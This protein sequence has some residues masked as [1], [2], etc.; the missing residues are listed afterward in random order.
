MERSCALVQGAR[1]GEEQILP[2]RRNRSHRSAFR[3]LNSTRAG[4]D[5]P[6]SVT[7]STRPLTLLSTAVICAAIPLGAQAQRAARQPQITS[8]SAPVI[9]QNGLRFR[10]LNRN[11]KLD[12]YEDW[13]LTPAAR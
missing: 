7:M 4:N 10:D 13:R 3:R 12:P 5:N 8:R 6:R 9:E 2:V 11:G 1:P